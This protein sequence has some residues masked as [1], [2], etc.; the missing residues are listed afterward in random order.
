MKRIFII[1][2]LSALLLGCKKQE[3]INIE[4]EIQPEIEIENAETLALEKKVFCNNYLEQVNGLLAEDKEANPEMQ[5]ALMEI[6]YSPSLQTCIAVLREMDINEYYKMSSFV[7]YDI[8]ASKD[9]KP[10]DNRMG[11]VDMLNPSQEFQDRVNE[12]KR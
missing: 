5:F 2:F 8:L 7:I 12:L 9:I 1:F 6:F 4:P 3:V 10:Y 11:D